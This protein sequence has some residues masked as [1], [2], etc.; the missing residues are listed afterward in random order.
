MQHLREIIETMAESWKFFLK[1]M[2]LNEEERTIEFL[3]H[4]GLTKIKFSP[5]AVAMM[6]TAFT[7]LHCCGK[8]CKLKVDFGDDTVT[9]HAENF[10]MASAEIQYLIGY[11]VAQRNKTAKK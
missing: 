7:E 4:T 8:E 2:G 10:A 9:V 1:G 5:R 6:K 11:I 3:K